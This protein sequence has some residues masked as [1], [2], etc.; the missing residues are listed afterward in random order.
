MSESYRLASD[1]DMERLLIDLDDVP[2]DGKWI[3][4]ISDKKLKRSTLQNNYYWLLMTTI[5]DSGKG[6]H[7]VKEVV[8]AACKYLF[9]QIW[10][11]DNE[12]EYDLY[13]LWV[14]ARPLEIEWYCEHHLSTSKLNTK[15]FAEYLDSIITYYGREIDLPM[16]DD[17]KLLEY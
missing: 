10:F 4:T 6:K 17:R 2:L 1:S 12:N 7:D 13:K 8:S 15:Q 11:A 3:I 9:K 5:A 16:P 14:A